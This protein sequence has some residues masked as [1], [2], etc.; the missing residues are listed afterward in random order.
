MTNI[1]VVID[2]SGSMTAIKDDAIGGFNEFLNNTRGKQNQRWWVWLFD[3]L[4]VDLIH[5]GVRAE[6]VPELDDQ[7]FLPRGGTPL[8]DAVGK[9]M[10]VA[11]ENTADKNV[12]VVLTDGQENSSKEWKQDAVLKDLGKAK[13]DD[14]QIVFLGVGQEAWTA[15]GAFAGLGLNVSTQRSGDSVKGGYGA[16]SSA[17]ASYMSAGT[18]TVGGLNVDADGKAEKS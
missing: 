14:W 8:Y 10:A 4:G 9:A 11:R 15:I 6:D 3:T 2:R 5:D 1:H 17:V 12:F 16:A 13:D 7:T 18:R